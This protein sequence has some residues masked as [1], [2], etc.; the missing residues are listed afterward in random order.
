VSSQRRI[1]H[2]IKEQN[3]D[4]S[5]CQE[6][7]AMRFKEIALPENRRLLVSY[8]EHWQNCKRSSTNRKILNRFSRKAGIGTI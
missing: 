7:G 3:L 5:S 2:Y 6:D 8:S 4:T 1:H